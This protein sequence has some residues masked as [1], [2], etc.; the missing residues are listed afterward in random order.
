MRDA[1]V[2]DINSALGL[3]QGTFVDNVLALVL[4]I[5]WARLIP[6]AFRLVATFIIRIGR[7]EEVAR[8]V[9][10]PTYNKYLTFLHLVLHP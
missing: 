8:D 3:K 9:E 2:L 10:H 6:F 7:T 5:S 1:L 4:L